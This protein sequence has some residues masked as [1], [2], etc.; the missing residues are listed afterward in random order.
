[1]KLLIAP[2]SIALASAS[3]AASVDS[4]EVSGD[5]KVDGIHFSSDGSVITKAPKD[6]K[7]VLNGSGTPSITANIGDFYID[8]LN[9]RLYG[10]YNGTWGTGVSLVGPQG[11]QGPKG[12]TG[13][14]GSGTQ[15]NI[16]DGNDVLIGSYL[17][18]AILS[19]GSNIVSFMKDRLFHTYDV[20]HNNWEYPSIWYK[21]YTQT[22]CNGSF[23]TTGITVPQMI[24]KIEIGS[25]TVGSPLYKILKQKPALISYLSSKEGPNSCINSSGSILATPTTQVGTISVP[26]VTPFSLQ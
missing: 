1:M 2:V 16:Y 17:T 12:D 6:G 5:L 10:P 3:Y 8:T 20:T 25:T 7:T 4:V 13:A 15:L 24:Y 18:T 23:Y 14:T 11:I 22:N 21:Y 26:L 19:D 9:N